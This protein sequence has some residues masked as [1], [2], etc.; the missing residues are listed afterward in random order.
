MLPALNPR[1]CVPDLIAFLGICL[2]QNQEE[3]QNSILYSSCSRYINSGVKSGERVPKIFTD[4][5]KSFDTETKSDHIELTRRETYCE[6]VSA[7][8][9]TQGERVMV[10]HFRHR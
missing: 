8:E 3:P 9:G 7:C 5:L 1:A 4:L 6:N 2:K 10:K